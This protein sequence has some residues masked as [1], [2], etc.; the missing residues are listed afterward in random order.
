MR[1]PFTSFGR[2]VT[3]TKRAMRLEEVRGLIERG[4]VGTG[5]LLAYGNGRSYGDSCQNCEHAVVPMASAGEISLDTDTGEVFGPQPP[6]HQLE[7]FVPLSDAGP[8]LDAVRRVAERWGEPV[9]SDPTGAP[10]LLYCELRVVRGDDLWLAPY[11]TADGG[12]TLALAFGMNR[13]AGKRVLEA[14]SDMERAIAPFAPRPH[15]AKLHSMRPRE[16]TA[17]FGD[18]WNA[19]CDLCERR[20]P[21]R[22]FVNQW[23]A[24]YLDSGR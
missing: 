16:V 1:G 12:D 22:K 18:K 3:A 11:A 5:S 10:L 9:A 7:Y 24:T 17:L 4:E 23:A 2:T 19:F 6:E 13:V 14:A 15:W 20:D 8:A 21:G